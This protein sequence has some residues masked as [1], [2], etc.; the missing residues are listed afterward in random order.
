MRIF[1][2]EH[3]AITNFFQEEG[4]IDLASMARIIFNKNFYF[5]GELEYN[6]FHVNN[7]LKIYTIFMYFA[8][9]PVVLLIDFIIT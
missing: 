2:W 8:V 9:M 3:A 6:S 1:R 7:A 4:W 5:L